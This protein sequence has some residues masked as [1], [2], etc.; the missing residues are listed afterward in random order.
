MF[1]RPPIANRCCAALRGTTFRITNMALRVPPPINVHGRIICCGMP[2]IGQ[3][4][5]APCVLSNRA[6]GPPAVPMSEAPG[7]VRQRGDCVERCLRGTGARLLALV[8]H[9]HFIAQVDL[10]H[11]PRVNR[12]RGGFGAILARSTLR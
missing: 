12:A 2:K 10:P 7:R 9:Y 11:P 8:S 1:A 4:R 5:A 3:R 6:L